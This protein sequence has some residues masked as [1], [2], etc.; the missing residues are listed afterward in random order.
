MA[1][2]FIGFG[3]EILILLILVTQIVVP[4]FAPKVK[5]FWLFR[6]KS[7]SETSGVSSLD[8]LN[9]RAETVKKAKDELNESVSSAE[10]KLKEIKSKT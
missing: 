5:Y 3:L 1:K 4:M 2:F 8:E 7:D 6:G 9:Q 10:E